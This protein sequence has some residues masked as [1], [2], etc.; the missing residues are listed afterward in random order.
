MEAKE[1][2]ILKDFLVLRIENLKLRINEL[3]NE[4]E[5]MAAIHISDQNVKEHLI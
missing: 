3:L 2:D 1:L 5:D 4:K